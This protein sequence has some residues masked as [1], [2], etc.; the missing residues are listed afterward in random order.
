MSK[1]QA[2]NYQAQPKLAPKN[3]NHSSAQSFGHGL[4]DLPKSVQEIF[5]KG[6]GDRIDARTGKAGK[7]LKWLSD[8]QGEIQTQGINNLFTATLAPAM[9]A[10]NPFAK[11]DENTK[12]YTAWRQPISA[13]IAMTAGLGMTYGINGFMENLYNQGYFESIDLRVEPSKDYLKKAYKKHC[14]ETGKT[15]SKGGLKDYSEKF[16]E[17]RLDFFTA[18][19][20]ENPD[21]IKF[22]PETKAILVNGQDIQEGVDK[23]LRVPG[24]ETKEALD[25]YLS[26]NNYHQRTFGDFLTERFG[27]EFYPSGD[28]K[29]KVTGAKLS[30]I[31]AMDFLKEMGLVDEKVTETA[32]RRSLGIFQQDRKVPEYIKNLKEEANVNMSLKGAKKELEIR[33][34]LDT[35]NTQA[36]MGEELGKS[37]LTTM[38]QLFHQYNIDDMHANPKGLSLPELT[39]KPLK[40][41]LVVFKELF[42]KSKLE[43]FKSG[44]D[45]SH[46][47]KNIL[48]NSV[49]RMA[50][51]AKNYKNYTGIAFNLI[52]TAI[53]CTIL[54]WAYPRIMERFFPELTK[55]EKKPEDAKGGN[56]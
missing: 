48:K 43:G 53:S 46:F 9:I 31:K 28:L 52:T 41:A 50:E 14:K 19:T 40:E 25:K 32:L 23:A 38:G 21:N 10:F 4:S 49:K 54:N 17:K 12:K 29:P 1:I 7:A 45:A 2:V 47:G 6:V 55:S 18:L 26:V 35:R 27:F 39:K 33:G 30:E 36:Y 11:Q 16:N 15:Y 3:A 22:N 8:T 34:K 51:N 42:E 44:Q 20:T 56:K 24:F 37:K 5:V 13:V